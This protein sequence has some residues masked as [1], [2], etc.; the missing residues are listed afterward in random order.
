MSVR[1]IALGLTLALTLALGGT[2]PLLAQETEGPVRVDSLVVLGNERISDGQIVRQS[3]LSEGIE[4][5]GPDLQDAIQ[6]LFASGDFADVEIRVSP[7]R[8]AVFYIVVEERPYVFG[9]RFE[10]LAHLDERSVRDSA[11]LPAEGPLNPASIKRTQGVVRQRLAQRGFPRSQI[12]T[13]LSPAGPELPGYRLT[14]RVDEGPRLGVARVVFRGNQAFT[15]EE[16]RAAMRTG[17]EGFFW[18]QSGGFR[19]E[20]YREDLSERL[21][22]FYA[23]HGYIDFAVLE[24]T[25]VVD[26]R[27]GK[28]RIEVQ[29]E[30]GPQY[31]LSDFRVSGSRRFPAQELRNM[32]GASAALAEGDT[33]GGELPPFDQVGFRESARDVE[34]LYRN[35]GYLQ[36]Q[37]SGRIQKVRPDS[38]GGVPRVRARWSVREGEPS[39]VRQIRIVGNDFTHDRIIRDRI[40]LLPGDIYSQQ[41]LVNSIQRVQGLGFFEQIP[42]QEAVS[43]DFRE[44]GDVDIQLRVQEKSTGNLNFGAS[45]AAVTGLAGFIGYDQPNLFGQAK[46]LHF[47]WLFGSRTNDLEVSYSDPAIFG[48]DQSATI[49]LMN[50]R[51]I[52]RTFSVGTRRQIGGSLE[53]GTPL[54]DLRNTRVF[55]GYS[56]FR[57]E[58]SDVLGSSLGDSPFLSAG[59]RS[60]MNLRLVRDTRN[61]TLFPTV[62]SQNRLSARFTGG[63]LGGDGEFAKYTFESAW[64]APVAQIGGGLESVPI[65]FTAGVT[66]RGGLVVGDNPFFRERFFMGGSQFGE[67]LRG[68]DEAT[69]TPQGHV[70]R[71]AQIEGITNLERSG[72]AYF[73][74]T[75]QF[76]VKLSSNIFLSS[77]VDAGNIWES[78]G[79][80]NPS[81]LLAGAGVGATLVT[82]F[83]PLGIDYAYGFN[84][85]DVLGRPDPGWKLHFKLGR[86]F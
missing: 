6:R 54:F 56:I 28:G 46:N 35:S 25:V 7:G 32:Y 79:E 68:Y 75:T 33:A 60:T 58:V 48:S 82:P 19:L 26:R 45:A 29:V 84:R 5:R 67:Q 4:V 30:E 49:R 44:D 42:P 69:V 18:W 76:G 16:L 24:D 72:G 61:S 83:G 65:Q 10:G 59:T 39:Y 2:S 63:P 40:S 71:N 31:R 70:P 57:D 36:A 17:S 13:V 52:F 80:F 9:Y 50:S 53:V 37:V 74:T 78:A 41:R 73:S 86:V 23:R 8:P 81:D 66:F 27:T 22:D 20:E 21:P 64:H 51:D 85:R 62:G 55:L 47:R 12:D 14:F 1:R 3:G 15:D 77:F 34:D 38:A 11:G 43:V